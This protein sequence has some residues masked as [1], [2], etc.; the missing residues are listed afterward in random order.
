VRH[1]P[2]IL[3]RHCNG[4]N[5]GFFTLVRAIRLVIYIYY[6]PTSI[7]RT[8]IIFYTYGNSCSK[9]T[10]F[11][12][13][14]RIAQTLMPTREPILSLQQ[15][16]CDAI[17][18]IGT[19]DQVLR[20]VIFCASSVYICESIVHCLRI[21]ISNNRTV[22]TKYWKARVKRTFNNRFSGWTWKFNK[23]TT[24]HIKLQ[25]IYDSHTCTMDSA[26]FQFP[27]VFVS[28]LATLFLS[29]LISVIIPVG[30]L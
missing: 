20:S 16:Y 23:C 13:L 21:I 8:S 2:S 28:M 7:T 17:S 15:T 19:I 1:S 10:Q 12:S 22:Y 9:D 4:W 6:L 11:V 27:A 25:Y 5:G 29:F 24:I 14:K 18:S 26:S 30:Q 3:C